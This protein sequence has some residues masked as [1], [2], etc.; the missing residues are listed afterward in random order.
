[1]NI[2][3]RIPWHNDG[4]NGHICSE[5][6]KNTYCVGQHSYPGDLIKVTRKLDWETR[7]DVKGKPC[8]SLAS[9]IPPCSLSINAFGKERM[10]AKVD[11]PLWFNPE[12]QS[13]LLDLEES[14]VCIWPYE[15]M[16]GEDVKR[17]VGNG[18]KYDYD[19]RLKNAKDYFSQL[20]EGKSLLFYYANYSN[21]FSEDEAQKYVLVGISRLK[22]VG[23]IQ[24]YEGASEEVKTKYAGGFVWQ[25]PLTSNYPDEGFVIPYHKYKDNPEVLERIAL[26]PDNSR[27]FKYASRPVS[28]DDSLVLVE[29][30]IEISSYLIEIG[31]KTQNWEERRKWLLTLFSEL[32]KKRGAY[33]G[34]PEV[35]VY[36]DFQEALEYYKKQVEA[37]NDKSAF[38]QIEQILEGEIDNVEGLEITGSRIKQIRR[39]WQLLEGNI[40]NVLKLLTRFN[41]SVKQIQNIVARDRAKNSLSATLEDIESNPYILCEQY[42]GDD[43]DDL[44]SFASIDHG[45]VPNP[46]LGLE[47]IFPNNSAERFRALCVDSLKRE[48]IHSFVSQSKVLFAVNNRLSYLPEWKSHQF[49]DK[50]FEVDASFISEAVT[51][52]KFEDEFYLYLREVRQDEEQIRSVVNEL[53]NRPDIALKVEISERQFFDLLRVETSI[54][55]EKAPDQYEEALRG[56]AKVCEKV[57]TK[58]VCVISGAAGT[59]KTTILKS[60]IKSIEKAHGIGTGI[61]LL[62]P[63]GKASERIKEKTQ[64]T[65]STI[66]SFLAK[67]NWLND[68]FTLKRI[69]GK[70]DA[71]VTTLII[72][73][74]SMI[75]LSLFAALFRS[76]HWNSVQR[77]ILVG[78]PNQLPPIGR[79]KVFSDVIE[80][81]KDA[82]SGNLGR[83]DI[84]VRQLENIATG[85]G[86]GILELAEIYIQENQ[87]GDNFDKTKQEQILKR[88]QQ[89]D[90]IDKDL[91]VFYWKEMEDLET[92]LKS[93]ITNDLK[94]IANTKSEN[95]DLNDLWRQ[96]IKTDSEFPNP[97]CFQMLS[98]YRGEYFGSDY[99]NGFFQQLFNGYQASKTQLDGIALFDKVIQ[100]R[101]RPLSNKI[102][103]YSWNEKKN[104]KIDIYNGEIGF[105][106]PH[107]FDRKKINWD[108]FTL[109]NLQ[110]KFDRR[111]DFSVN[112]GYRKDDYSGRTMFN[113]PVEEN[114]ELGYVISVHKAQ[115]SEFNRVYFILPKKRS[116]LLSMELLYTAVTRAQA[117][118][119]I[120]A[121]ED[122]TTF[123]ELSRPEKS[124]IR[125][126]N[127]SIFE[128]KPLPDVL[129]TL[130]S[131]WYEDGKV[132]STLAECFVRS[133]SEM[134]I[135]NIL[136]LNDIPFTY[137]QPKFA[138]DGSMYLP[139]FTINW[140]GE[141]YYWEHVGRLDLPEYENHWNTKQAWYEKHFPGKL[142]TTFE[143][144][145]QTEDIRK[146]L[147]DKFGVVID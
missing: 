12:A 108:G 130:T 126:I 102:S 133:K 82:H 106:T 87:R 90:E 112:Y 46:E 124:N 75:D 103:A 5:P 70:V 72:D 11:P 7:D 32:W 120:F 125:R 3:I 6:E 69:G 132:I 30:L 80:W 147:S 48:N 31:D 96:A 119:T 62:A 127:S 121:Q 77:L 74:C 8:G 40:P 35:L 65:A 138:G 76:I 85:E 24:Y 28:E 144:P 136:H 16:Y 38:R 81:M 95:E 4:W 60:I 66:H 20:V 55:L 13:A 105:V 113:E 63:T 45:I 71:T 109:K 58:P 134:N 101:N 128:F 97:T 122:V 141:E 131:N 19:L 10:K 23:K 22:K 27:N 117:H 9:G 17:E 14:T 94:E 114:L 89:G 47:N 135:A 104:V 21:P 137:E 140:R 118:L 110:V 59:G 25:M 79:G 99:L 41:L 73:E 42:I 18:Q 53:Q 129:F 39:N 54:L 78:D 57:F 61:I 146:I 50:Y 116:P 2:T 88:V 52:R 26:I 123:I 43:V 145:N 86:N 37:G 100:I 33:P 142:I 98:P 34:L 1:M 143:G 64:K 15:Q 51:F 49:T 93:V 115:G 91:S 92:L 36:L 29:R 107:P 139:D 68:N 111:N 84:N 67:G 44:I 56:Q 83:L